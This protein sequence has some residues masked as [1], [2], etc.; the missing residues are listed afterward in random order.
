MPGDGGHESRNGALHVAGTAA[1]Q[2]AIHHLARERIVAPSAA[3][4]HDIGVAG[5]TEMRGGVADAGKQ[6]FGA[7]E[8]Q[9]R[10]RET[11]RRQ[12]RG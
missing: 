2:N 10:H 1:I 8:R 6:V 4:R 12:R 3:G 5:K 7:A 9:L 11:E